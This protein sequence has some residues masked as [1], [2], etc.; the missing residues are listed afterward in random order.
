MK[1]VG[2]QTYWRHGCDECC[3]VGGRND[4]RAWSDSKEIFLLPKALRT[5]P[6]DN[7][8]SLSLASSVFD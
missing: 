6:L 7:Q 4:K 1:V 3:L 8:S 2:R 5:D